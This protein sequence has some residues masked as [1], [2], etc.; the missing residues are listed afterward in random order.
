[1]GLLK[2]HGKLPGT[3]KSYHTFF[4]GNG[5]CSDCPIK[6][7]EI[8]GNKKD[9]GTQDAVAEALRSDRNANDNFNE[10][11]SYPQDQSPVIFTDLQGIRRRGIYKRAQGFQEISEIEVPLEQQSFFPEDDVAGWEYEPESQSE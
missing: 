5:F 9:Q 7:T 2:T 1:M 3:A 4:C 6:N 8:M 10:T 11:R